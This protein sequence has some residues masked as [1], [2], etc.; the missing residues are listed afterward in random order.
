MNKQRK[1]EELEIKRYLQKLNY[2]SVFEYQKRI[3]LEE[4]IN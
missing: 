4:A 2:Q 3:E 1:Q